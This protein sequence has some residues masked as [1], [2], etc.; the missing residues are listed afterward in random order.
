MKIKRTDIDPK[1]CF[2]KSE[3]ARKKN[4]S[5]G[6]ITQLIKAG[7]LTIIVINGGELIYEK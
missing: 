1:K 5:P 4:V 2:T 7:E 3:Y 6:R